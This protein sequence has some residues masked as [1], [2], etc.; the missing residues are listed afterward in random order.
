MDHGIIFIEKRPPGQ[1]KI[2][3]RELRAK[4][5]GLPD[6]CR[7]HGPIDVDNPGFRCTS[8]GPTVYRCSTCNSTF[9]E[10][11]KFEY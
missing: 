1:T 6:E 7:N 5:G 3:K 4:L 9:T 11:E 8:W 10:G 2:A